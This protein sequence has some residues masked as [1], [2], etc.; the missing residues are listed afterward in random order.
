MDSLLRYA[1]VEERCNACGGTFR[2]TLYDA[3]MTQ[4]VYSD[5]EPG[6]PCST[7]SVS[8]S[9]LAT[10]LP[11]DLLESIDAAWQRIAEIAQDAELN[12]RVGT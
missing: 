1:Y 8:Q 4:Q 10:T 3:L 9:A 7:C 2:V 5:W 12:L 6:R 11:S